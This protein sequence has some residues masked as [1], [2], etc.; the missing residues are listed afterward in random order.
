MS[1]KVSYL[2]S[3]RGLAAIIVV[4]THFAAVYYPHA[5]FGA[6]YA[7]TSR[8]EDWLRQP[9][10]SLVMSGQFAVAVFFILSGYVLSIGFL[11]HGADKRRLWQAMV[12]RPLRLGGL[13]IFT[14]VLGYALMQAGRF[15]WGT[16]N[17]DSRWLKTFWTTTPALGE[18]LYD[19]CFRTFA[20]AET[21]NPP[22]WTIHKE[23]VGSYLVFASLAMTRRLNQRWRVVWLAALGLLTFRSLYVGFVIGMAFAE[24]EVVSLRSASLI[25]LAN[26]KSSHRHS[27][28]KAAVIALL[29]LPGVWLASQLHYQRTS[30]ELHTLVDRL[31]K[32]FADFGTGGSA[33][34]GATL[35]FAAF[36]LSPRLQQSIDRPSLRYVGRVSYALYVM[37]FLIIGSVTYSLTL[38]LQTSIGRP[39]AVATSGL[40]SA[41][42]LFLCAE[43]V[44]RWVDQPCIRLS[45]RVGESIVRASERLWQRVHQL[46][47]RANQWPKSQP[48]Q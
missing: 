33:M 35:I 21:Y 17:N 22:L 2:D 25:S 9:P 41:L 44:T 11:K 34:C 7:K 10:L 36:W 31:T 38:L 39:A 27:R 46:R 15:D 19:L 47:Q 14:I 26:T 30:N 3:L 29:L 13:V 20:G 40:V 4:L 32:L 16:P 48:V 24:A 23:L 28:S 1:A 43:L 6:A 5:L 12:K 18:F 45:H 42:L 8:F 37:H